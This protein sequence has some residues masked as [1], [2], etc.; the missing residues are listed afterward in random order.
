[1]CIVQS[2]YVLR[3]DRTPLRLDVLSRGLLDDL[4][5]YHQLS[6]PL[7]YGHLHT[8]TPSSTRDYLLATFDPR[9]MKNT[10]IILD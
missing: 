7:R 2:C 1:M 6:C 3:L 5:A 8:P 4:L 9:T 10:N